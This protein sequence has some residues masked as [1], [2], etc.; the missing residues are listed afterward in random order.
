[1]A[2]KVLIRRKV[3]AENQ[4]E[5]SALLRG[6][7]TLTTNREGYISG[8]SLTRL[9]SPG[10]SLVISTWQ[11]AEDW[12]QWLQAPERKALQEKVD[13]LIGEETVY[14]LFEHV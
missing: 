2:V 12:K 9:D 5:L 14:E 4:Q 10:E 7:R 8:E 3:S 1:M 6:L 11:T 13:A